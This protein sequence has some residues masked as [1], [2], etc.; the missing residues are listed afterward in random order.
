MAKKAFGKLLPILLKVRCICS[1]VSFLF[2]RIMKT[3]RLENLSPYLDKDFMLISGRLIY[4]QQLCFQVIIHLHRLVQI[5]RSMHWC[6]EECWDMGVKIFSTTENFLGRY[7]ILI[8][9][10]AD[11]FFK[12]P[13]KVKIYII[14]LCHKTL[15][16]SNVIVHF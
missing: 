11:F 7:S 8:S 5:L 16:F 14:M 3:V 13:Q 10:W 6:E 2:K 1:L 9:D 4:R 15:P 12:M